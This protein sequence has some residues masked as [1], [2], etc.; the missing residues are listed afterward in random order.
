MKR[1]FYTYFLK[2]LV[3]V[4][5]FGVSVVAHDG[6]HDG[7]AIL[8]AEE[9]YSGDSYR[10]FPG[11][12][13]AR[14]AD[15][16]NGLISFQFETIRSIELRGDIVLEIWTNSNFRGPSTQLSQSSPDLRNL[17]PSRQNWAGRINSLR[18]T[19]RE[20]ENYPPKGSPV[21]DRPRLGGQGG[22][23]IY[24]EPNFEGFSYVFEDLEP[25]P[26]L[27]QLHKAYRNWNDKIASI[28]VEGPYSVL[29][30]PDADF[31]G[32][33]L[34]IDESIA[35]LNELSSSRGNYRNWNNAISSIEFERKGG[36][37]HRGGRRKA[38][39]GTLYEDDNF[40][41]EY[42]KLYEGQ[43][44]HNLKEWRWNDEASSIMVEDG[45][46]VVLFKDSNF[47][48]DSKMFDKDQASLRRL[49]GGWND[50]AS[51]LKV[52]KLP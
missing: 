2:P 6:N 7:Y 32:D 31:L 40:S 14:K 19:Y 30:Y 38:Y 9:D 3:G 12:E 33:P 5:F 50:Q 29:L 51:S 43:V 4:Y 26:T 8:Y 35:D 49:P 1:L 20:D 13:A 52:V 21:I 23:V 39:A 37:G 47:R 34:L 18:A 15:L 24:T 17:P 28:Y 10:L 42:F 27:N 36:G 45:F 11:E 46:Q 48:G 16:D 25:A 44:L 22:V 41:G